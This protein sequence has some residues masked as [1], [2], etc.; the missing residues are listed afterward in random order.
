MD[1]NNGMNFDPMTGE[2]LKPAAEPVAEAVAEPVTEVIAEPVAEAVEAVAEPVAEAVAEPVAEAVVEPVTEAVVEPVAA[3][4]VPAPQPAPEPVYTQPA[5]QPVVYAQPAE[6]PVV[7]TQPAEQPVVYTQ[8]AAQPV[9]VQP[10]YVQQ[11]APQAAP[12]G[13]VVYPGREIVGLLFGIGSLISGICGL[14]TIVPF[15]GW[16]FGGI[17]AVFGI[18]YAIVAKVQWSTIK[19]NATS[20]TGKIKAG[21]GMATAGLILS[22]IGIVGGIIVGVIVILA[23]AGIVGAGLLDS[24][25]Y[26]F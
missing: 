7:Y 11:P 13:E 26:S 14:F 10:V 1:G 18:I 22:I 21:N 9:Y 4:P 3:E 17:T 12:A 5:E 24:L 8:P 15:Y 2:P 20:F 19:K 16:I 25:G 23:A 6:Q